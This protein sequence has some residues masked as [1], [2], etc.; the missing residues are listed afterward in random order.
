[1]ISAKH[2][3]VHLICRA[4]LPLALIVTGSAEMAHAVDLDASANFDIRSQPLAE[5]LVDFGQQ[6]H[7]QIMSSSTALDNHLVPALQGSYSIAQ[8]LK[9]LLSGT[10]LTYSSIGPNTIAVVLS[11]ATVKLKETAVDAD[12]KPT[13]I[14]EHTSV[15][16]T[17]DSAVTD[18]IPNGNTAGDSTQ[19][20]LAEVIVTAERRT[21]D[22]EKTP[23]TVTVL[24]AEAIEQRGQT[25]YETILQNVPGVVLQSPPSP[26]SPNPVVAIRG[27]GTDGSNKPAATAVYEDGVIINNE[28]LQFYDLS[29]IEVL[30]GPQATLYGGV[31]TAGAVNIITNDPS[32]KGFEGTGRLTLGNAALVHV[33]GMLNV[34]IGDTLAVR[35]G[36]NEEGRDNDVTPEGSGRHEIN[37]RAKL[38]YTPNDTV[39]LLVGSEVYRFS[40][41]YTDATYAMDEAG[42]I[43]KPAIPTVGYG[44]TDTNKFFAN[45]NV[46]LGWGILTYI[47]AVQ[48]STSNIEFTAPPGATNV[49]TPYLDVLTQELRIA[50]DTNSSVKWV[51]GLYYRHS[52]Q[53][54]T[55]NIGL[56]PTLPVV[57]TPGFGPLSIF[58]TI[59]LGEVHP[60]AQVTVPL[61][62]AIRLTGGA[63]YSRDTVNYPFAT[64]IFGVQSAAPFNQTYHHVDELARVEADVASNSLAYAS[65]STGYRPGGPTSPGGD[66]YAEEKVMAYEIGTKNRFLQDNLQIN[67]D[68]YYNDYPNFQN[69][70]DVFLPD[71]L[72][73][74]IT[75]SVP[76]RMYG[77]ELSV[78]TRVTPNDTVTVEPAWES[79][80]YTGDAVQQLIPQ[81]TA[82][83]TTDGGP[84]PHAPRWSVSAD[85]EHNFRLPNGA[86]LL[87]SG[88]GHYQSS[89]P[90][91]FDSCIYS[92]LACAS[93]GYSVAQL[94][95]KAYAIADAS[96]TYNFA[97]EK[98]S[99]TA[100]MRNLGNELYKTGFG[101]GEVTTN[102]PRTYGLSFSAKW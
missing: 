41:V 55:V 54:K 77:A 57:E 94:M 74:P 30:S 51:A 81:G 99:M 33:D 35:F 59:A 29:R 11:E 53:E 21:E 73:L 13:R 27:V 71:G 2:S 62:T 38:L 43:Q 8:A 37:A 44:H 90:V 42:N 66:P 64:T 5:A 98:Y 9:R 18:N 48:N 58:Q 96:L 92:A 15:P 61:S 49:D 28:N 72:L 14:A 23:I 6:A 16:A 85:Y 32:T 93:E 97:G 89:Q 75:S 63:S 91:V 1:M 7:V 100:F 56:T 19:E 40:G 22:L 70:A 3:S 86:S 65:F 80:H 76:A 102:A 45:L 20:G 101:Q 50:S 10:P 88:D 78:I 46:N 4:L 60:F 82:V 31:A 69:Q 36:F 87:F 68:I 39:S 34:P 12:P 95:Q 83:L 52:K 47:P 67:F 79:A 24:N 84:V 25:T 17:S 26:D